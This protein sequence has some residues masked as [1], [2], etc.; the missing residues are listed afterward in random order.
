MEF[1]ERRLMVELCVVNVILDMERNIDTA[2][3]AICVD[4]EVRITSEA[5]FNW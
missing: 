4:E 1:H 5:I 2:F 3:I